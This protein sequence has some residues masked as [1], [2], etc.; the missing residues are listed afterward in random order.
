MK[1]KFKVGDFCVLDYSGGRRVRITRVEKT[2]DKK[3]TVYGYR[4]KGLAGT[5][6]E[7]Q[8]TLCN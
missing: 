8:L 2:Y 6:P 1:P 3:G 4:L 5:F 7:N